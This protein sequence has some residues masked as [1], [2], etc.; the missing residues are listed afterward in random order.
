MGRGI[1]AVCDED[2]V[3]AKRLMEYLGRRKDIPLEA[4][5]FTNI[6]LLNTYAAEHRI[7][8]LLIAGA[9]ADSLLEGNH[10]KKV[11]LLSEEQGEMGI[12]KYQS[13][14]IVM[15]EVMEYCGGSGQLGK[16]GYDGQAGIEW[17]GVYSPVKRCGRTSLAMALGQ[18]LSEEFRVLYLNFE[19]YPG[20]PEPE[21]DLEVDFSDIMLSLLEGKED[22]EEQMDRAVRRMGAMDYIPPGLS[23]LDIRALP[24]EE[25]ER[26]FD[27]ME[28][29][30]KYDK[31]ILDMGD[32]VDE[33]FQIL[34]RCAYIFM[35]VLD[36]A[37]SQA[38]MEQF[39]YFLEVSELGD[40]WDHIRQVHVPLRESLPW[41]MPAWEER[42]QDR[43][44]GMA[45]GIVEELYGTAKIG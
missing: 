27:A 28:G 32:S 41:E 30:N 2:A 26:F 18:A 12:Y 22:L 19:E 15:K 17:I 33:V 35:P 6:E 23:F 39:E 21:Q 45:R 14:D 36:D 34:N 29:W 40:M 16:G 4:R 20:F 3:Y 37:A 13:A 42:G 31:V 5:A 9:L 24:F 25:W 44:A 7:D 1:F 38:K 8:V 43:L 11:L 10:I